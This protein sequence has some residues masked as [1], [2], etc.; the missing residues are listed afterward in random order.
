MALFEDRVIN[1]NSKSSYMNT[2]RE[3][4]PKAK[5][6]VYYTS[7]MQ[8]IIE[9][10]ENNERKAAQLL[11]EYLTSLAETTYDEKIILSNMSK[12]LSGFTTEEQLRITSMALA[13]ALCKIA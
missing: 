6:G 1:K 12:M 13:Q 3:N 5:S 10:K 2:G 8:G 9:T 4:K 11:S 7:A